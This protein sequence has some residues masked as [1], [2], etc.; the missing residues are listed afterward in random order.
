MVWINTREQEHQLSTCAI[1]V[2]NTAP[3]CC[4]SPGD[5]VWWQGR[6]A[7]W[8]P[9]SHGHPIERVGGKMNVANVLLERIGFSG[10]PRPET[11]S[12]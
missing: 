9:K 4:I 11:V 8:T 10:V 7:Y 6:S 12:K 5:V 1:Y 3:A 2:K